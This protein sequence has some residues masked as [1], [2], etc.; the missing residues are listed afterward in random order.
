GF[1]SLLWW[2]GRVNHPFL[3]PG[4]RDLA[5]FQSLLWWIGR[6]NVATTTAGAMG[7]GGFQSLLWWIGRVNTIVA[8]RSATT[9][10]GF[11][12][13]CGGSVASTASRC[14]AWCSHPGCFNPC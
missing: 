7:T 8:V 9:F 2:I 12:P 6:V 5:V 14:P 1:Q 11:N 3:R 13:C 10:H 4:H